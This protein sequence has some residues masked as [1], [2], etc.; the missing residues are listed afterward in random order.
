VGCLFAG[1]L[2]LDEVSRIVLRSGDRLAAYLST[3]GKLYLYRAADL[4]LRGVLLDVVTLL[5]LSS[6]RTFPFVEVAKRCFR[7]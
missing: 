1:L 4:A 5:E 7:S 2:A 3:R 6:L